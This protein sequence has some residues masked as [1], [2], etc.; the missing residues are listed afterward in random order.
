MKSLKLDANRR[1]R[2][3]SKSF[4]IFWKKSISMTN[5]NFQIY[6][7]ALGLTK[8]LNPLGMALIN[9]SIFFTFVPFSDIASD[10]SI[11]LVKVYRLLLGRSNKNTWKCCVTLQSVLFEALKSNSNNQS[12][13]FKQQAY[14]S[15]FLKTANWST[16]KPLSC[17]IRLPPRSQK[18]FEE[19]T[20]VFC[21]SPNQCTQ[22]QVTKEGKVQVHTP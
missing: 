7:T 18:L 9:E 13:L 16:Q 12:I 22:S 2:E 20:C 19:E 11:F 4:E 10:I 15:N 14:C 1:E 21:L 3:R 17:D 6:V 5:P 8:C